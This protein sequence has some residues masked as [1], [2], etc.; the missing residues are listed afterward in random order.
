MLKEALNRKATS[1]A[2][3][4]LNLEKLASTMFIKPSFELQNQFAEFVKQVDKSKFVCF[5]S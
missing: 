3:K 2:Q 4:N 5:L 1:V